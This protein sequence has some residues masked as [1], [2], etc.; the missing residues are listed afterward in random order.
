[1]LEVA[2]KS[3]PRSAVRSG[4]RWPKGKDFAFTVF[5]DTDFSTLANVKPVY[6]LLAEQGILVTKSVWPLR[7]GSGPPC[8][9]LDCEDPDYL[10]WLLDL[11]SRGFEIGLHTVSARGARRERT[12]EGIERFR[13]LFGGE[14]ITYSSHVDSPE[15]IYFGPDRLSGARKALYR[16]YAQRRHGV[17]YRGHVEGDELFWG[18]VCRSEVKYVRNF[19]FPDINTLKACPEMPYHDPDRSYVNYWYASSEGHNAESFIATISAANQD[20]LAAE[21]GACIMYTH[22]A[23]GF[24]RDGALH[25]EFERLIRRL[26]RMNGWFVPVRTLLDYLLEVKGSHRLS[27]AERRRLEW[28]W[29]L[30]KARVGGT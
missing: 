16:F 28:R 1:M 17:S 29:M 3:D 2:E 20:R 18:D 4:I 23:Y 24:V 8:D 5:D 12:I 19:V 22:F 6:D 15:G 30:H 13:S 14:P 26:A 21:G 9:G 10:R 27:P 25:P 11:Q 7:H